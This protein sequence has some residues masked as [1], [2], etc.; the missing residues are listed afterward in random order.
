MLT[1]ALA[2]ALALALLPVFLV[3]FDSVNGGKNIFSQ[4]EI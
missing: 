3:S 2:L 4:F 1:A